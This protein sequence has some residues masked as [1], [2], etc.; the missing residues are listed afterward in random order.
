[1]FYLIGVGLRPDHLTLEAVQAAEKCNRVFLDTYTSAYAQGNVKDL[2]EALAKEIL[3]LDRKGLEEGFELVL[4][5]AKAEE[6]D[7]ALLVFGN[8]LSATTHIQL[9]VD[10][11]KLGLE[12]KVVPGI[13]VY[14][15]LAQTGLDQYRFGRTCTIVE[16]KPGYEPE[17]FYG[18]IEK[19]FKAGM[20]TLCL[21][22]I[23][24]EQSRMMSVAQ[25]LTVLEKIEKKRG[26]GILKKASLVG[27][28]GLGNE[29]Q[30]VKQA[31]LEVLQKSSFAL[32]PQ[33]LVVAAPLN[34]KEKEALGWFA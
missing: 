14:D 5:N 32:Y 12:T 10:A 21:L 22:D 9:L 27:L 4:K 30:R 16:P 29:N 33:S 3:C 6:E 11:K 26:K 25:A 23:D 2:R 19:N 34:E 17:S 15:F 20:H 13:S 31:S 28:Y 18:V 8:P 7:V 24:A 1:M